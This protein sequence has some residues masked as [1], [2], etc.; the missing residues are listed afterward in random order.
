MEKSINISANKFQKEIYLIQEQIRY[1]NSLKNAPIDQ[2][3]INCL[4]IK[5][6]Q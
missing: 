5:S 2:N 1:L 4:V 6:I 3:G